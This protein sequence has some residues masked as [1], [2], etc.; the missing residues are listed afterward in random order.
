VLPGSLY[1][2]SFG[3]MGTFSGSGHIY[4]S[5]PPYMPFNNGLGDE[6]DVDFTYANAALGTPATV[7]GMSMWGCVSDACVSGLGLPFPIG[8]ELH[9]QPTFQIVSQSPVPEPLSLLLLGPGLAGV[10]GMK[11]RRGL[12]ANNLLPKRTCKK[13][14]GAH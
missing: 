2:S 11:R 9:R 14:G 8:A 12:E 7:L 5:G 13:Y 3:F 1:F 10:I 6:L 4:S